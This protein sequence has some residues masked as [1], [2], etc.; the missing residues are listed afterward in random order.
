MRRPRD[1]GAALSAAWT[2]FARARHVAPREGDQRLRV[3]R[4]RVLGRRLLGGLQLGGRAV[5]LVPRLRGPRPAVARAASQIGPDLERALER[6]DRRRRAGPARSAAPPSACSAWMS[7]GAIA[8]AASTSFI[9]PR[10]VLVRRGESRLRDRARACRRASPRARR[11]SPRGPPCCLAQP[12]TR[13]A[14][15]GQHIGLAPA[16]VVSLRSAELGDDLPVLSLLQQ[17]AREQRI[18]LVGRVS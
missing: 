11:R 8:S 4:A 12:E 15:R 7:S 13:E 17:R 5:E 3:E 2:A 14:E 6:L 16:H 9:A 1:S 18:G 10:Q